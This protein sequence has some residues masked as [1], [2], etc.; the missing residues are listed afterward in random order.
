LSTTATRPRQARPAY[1]AQ[2]AAEKAL[3]AVLVFL[4][5]EFPKT[6]DLD[7]LRNLIPSGW[8]VKPDHPALKG[9][10]DWVFKGRYPGDWPEPTV[11]DAQGATRQA[12]AV[13]KSVLHDLERHGFD[14]AAY[15]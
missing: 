13:W 3:K 4:Q 2:Q 15:R 12:R 8:E 9:L 1:H 11:A 14:V 7:G 10:T 5:V 6:Y